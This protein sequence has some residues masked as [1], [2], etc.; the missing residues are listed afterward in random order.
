MGTKVEI[1][2]LNSIRFIKKAI[3]SETNRLIEMHK[4]GEVILQETRGLNEDDFSTFAI[5][6]K[7]DED[8]YRYFP[9]PDLPPF[10]ISDE[11]IEK[12]REQMPPAVEEIR[13]NFKTTYGLPAV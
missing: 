6:T 10:F 4:K 3:E 7:E 9:E 2:N 13:N 12:I 5:R 11:M 8:D 1:K